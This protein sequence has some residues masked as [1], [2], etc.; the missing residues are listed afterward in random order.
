MKIQANRL[1]PAFL[2]HQSEYENAALRVLRSGRYILGNE[3]KAFEEEFADYLGEGECV[4]LASG[5]DSL[6]ITFRLLSI[7]KGDEV[8]VQG[9]TYI[10]SVMGITINGA[11]PVFAEPNDCFAMDASKLAALLTPRTKAVLVTHL[12]GMMTPMDAIVRFCREHNLFL[13]EDCAQAHGCKEN[14]KCAGTFGD[15]GCFS[16]YPTKNLGGFGD[17]GAV[18]V[19]SPELAEKFRIFRNYG[20]EKRYHNCMV[21]ANSRLDELQAAL[22]RVKLKHLDELNAEKRRIAER[23]LKEIN[24]PEILLPKTAPNTVNVWHQFVIRTKKRDALN[25]YLE[26]QGI[27]TQIHYPI[28]PHLSEAYSYLGFGKGALPKTEQLANTV[29]SVP[30]YV[31]LSDEEQE[32]IIRAINAF[33]KGEK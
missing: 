33:G 18:W 28:P 31:G 30:A 19:R 23:Y 22:L 1:E 4:G 9:N 7:G 16:F 20:S 17:G 21:G 26:R 5:L 11:T 8:L 32:Y 6:W 27:Q 15:V 3:T 12:Y 13:I 2:I 24:H 10:A 14:G 29:L 25:S